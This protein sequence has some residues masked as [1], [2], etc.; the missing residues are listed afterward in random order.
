MKKLIIYAVAFFVT[1]SIGFGMG[2]STQPEK[3]VTK[4]VKVETDL[5]DWKR[6]KEVDD[7]GFQLAQEVVGLCSQGYKAISEFDTATMT[8]VNK[9][10]NVKTQQILTVG[11]ERQELLKKLGY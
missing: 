5:T 9:E 4:E 10:T 8:R 2:Q 3:I 1:M 7:R 11:T 6:L